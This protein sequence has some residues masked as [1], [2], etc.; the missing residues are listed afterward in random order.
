MLDVLPFPDDKI[1]FSPNNL[2]KVVTLPT[3]IQD[4]PGSNLDWGKDYPDMFNGFSVPPRKCQDS[5]LNYA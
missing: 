1:F 3:C 5:A 4:V 2:A